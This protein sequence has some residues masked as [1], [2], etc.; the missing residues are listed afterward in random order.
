MQRTQVRNYQITLMCSITPH[1][2]CTQ[3]HLHRQSDLNVKPIRIS[4]NK[5]IRIESTS[6]KDNSLINKVSNSFLPTF[7]ALAPI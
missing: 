1:C 3:T 4:D 7:T 5:R 2:L 6:S